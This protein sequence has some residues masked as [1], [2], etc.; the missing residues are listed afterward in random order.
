MHLSTF[1]KILQSSYRKTVAAA[2]RLHEPAFP[3]FN[4]IT[5]EARKTVPTTAGGPFKLGKA[6]RGSCEDAARSANCVSR[7]RWRR[8]PT[9]RLAYRAHHALLGDTSWCATYFTQNTQ[10]ILGHLAQFT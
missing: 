3:H 8:T 6:A 4:P 5:P 9:P 1:A 7:P 2:E 10:N